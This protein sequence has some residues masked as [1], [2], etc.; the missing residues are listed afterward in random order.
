M[1]A[2]IVSTDVGEIAKIDSVVMKPARYNTTL[3][4]SSIATMIIGLRTAFRAASCGLRNGLKPHASPN[5][6]S[7][8]RD[9]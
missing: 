9:R 7:A 8:R 5:S 2:E 4:S 6:T 1:M 3:F